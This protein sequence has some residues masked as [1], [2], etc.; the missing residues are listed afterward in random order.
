MKIMK[1]YYGEQVYNEINI[2]SSLSD[3]VINRDSQKYY[4]YLESIPLRR[5]RVWP[6][7]IDAAAWAVLRNINDRLKG[8]KSILFL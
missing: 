2:E 3:D 1:S 8:R 5:E 6:N 7:R 4:N